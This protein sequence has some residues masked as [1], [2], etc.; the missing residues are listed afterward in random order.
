M[1]PSRPIHGV[2]ERKLAQYGE[3]FL[4]LIR[5][6][7]AEHHLAERPRIE[8]RDRPPAGRWQPGEPFRRGGRAV[9]R[10][11]VCAGAPGHV[12][13]Q[14]KHHRRSPLPLCAGRPQ[15]PTGPGTGLLWAGAGGTGPRAG[16]Y[17]RARPPVGCA[18]STTRWESRSPLMSCTSCA[19]I[20][21]V[22]RLKPE[23]PA[24]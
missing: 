2:G 18:P 12:R 4:A 13:R 22:W 24:G 3:R 8:T 7:C 23:K 19:C 20:T 21:C 16:P 9:R 17:S 1:P 14:A 6:Y 5:A 15:L 11:H 10:R